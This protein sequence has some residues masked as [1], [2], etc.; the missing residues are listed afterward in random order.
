MAKIFVTRR[1]PLV[2]IEMLSRAGHEVVISEK[3][4][5][6]TKDELIAVLKGGNFSAVMSVLT[7]TID[8]DVF[9]SAPTVKIFANYAIG[10]DNFD[11]AEGK[12][13]GVF[14]SS[15]RGGGAERVS[16]H[17]WA[18][19]LALACHVVDSDR[20]VR[21]GRY[22]GFDPLIFHGTELSG[23]T[24]GII[25]T[26]Q[27]GSAVA[28]KAVHGFHMKVA[29]FDM[30]RN[31]GLE[32]DVGAVFCPTIEAVLACADVVSLHVPLM[33]T[34]HHLMSAERLTLMKPTAFLVNTSRG[35][36]I[37]EEALVSALKGGTIAGAGLDVFEHEP[38]LASGLAELPN[39]VLTPHIASATAQ[40]RDDMARLASENIIACLSGARPPHNVY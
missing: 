36:V 31:E 29:Y 5:P 8:R 7:D 12:K 2:G 9:D 6:M 13:R 35:P 39:V 33:S 22:V 38:L 37:D 24:L 27:I 14:L 19:I 34:T 16:E 17:T 40:S 28:H 10:F 23:K 11:V 18:L 30:I 32:H 15:A 20:F 3:S 4:S 25:G 21:E 1:I 26:G